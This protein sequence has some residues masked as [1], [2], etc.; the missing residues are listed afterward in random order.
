[1]EDGSKGKEDRGQK[2]LIYFGKLAEQKKTI[3]IRKRLFAVHLQLRR[4]AVVGRVVEQ[5]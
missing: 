1:M 4:L 5:L 3:I 2:L